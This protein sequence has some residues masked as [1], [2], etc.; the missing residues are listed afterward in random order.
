M[1]LLSLFS[2]AMFAQSINLPKE[3]KFKFGDNPEWANPMFNDN[4]WVTQQLGK[5]FTKDSSYAWYRIKMVI[6]SGY[7]NGYWKRNQIISW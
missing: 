4:D 7:E 6:P 1:L 5:S 2:Q 3:S